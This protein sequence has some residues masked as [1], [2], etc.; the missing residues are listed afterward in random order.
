MGEKGA[1]YHRAIGMLAKQ[2][3]TTRYVL[4]I[5][6]R[7]GPPVKGGRPLNVGSLDGIVR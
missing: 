2:V 5:E 4:V 7:E 6:C 3:M 1:D